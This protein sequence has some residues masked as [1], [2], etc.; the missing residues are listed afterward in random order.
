MNDLNNYKTRRLI[1]KINMIFQDQLYETVVNSLIQ[2]VEFFE[3]NIPA[4]TEVKNT[5]E[6]INTYKDPLDKENRIK[7]FTESKMVLDDNCAFGKATDLPD[8]DLNTTYEAI[9][10]I[11]DELLVEEKKTYF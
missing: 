6:V 11:P 1:R 9:E 3:K 4:V 10:Y 5:K 2:F 8:T 7:N